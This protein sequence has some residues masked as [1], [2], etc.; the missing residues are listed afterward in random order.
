M[1]S[2]SE[3]CTSVDKLSPQCHACPLTLQFLSEASSQVSC[4]MQ[5][6]AL[7]FWNLDPI[8][9]AGEVGVMVIN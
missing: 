2:L 8:C 3:A 4:K 5:P 9:I 7:G 6:M 1:K